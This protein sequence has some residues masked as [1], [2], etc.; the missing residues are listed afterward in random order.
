MQELIWKVRPDVIVESGVAHGGALV[1]YA[2]ILELLG[3]GKV[4]GVD[5]EIRKYNRL[6]IEAHP[7]SHRIDLIEGDSL[8]DET[9]AA[10]RSRI[11]PGERVMVA[12]DSNHTRE[13]VRGELERYAPLVTPNSYLVVFD[14]V[15]ALVADAPPPARAGPRT[16]RSRR[17][18]TSSTATTTSRSTAPTSG[19]RSA[20]ARAASC[21]GGRATERTAPTPCSSARPPWRGLSWSSPSGTRTSAASS[22]APSRPTSS[23][24]TGWT[25]RGPVQ[26]VVQ[27]KRRHAA[28]A[29]LPGRAARRGEARPLHARRDL[30]RGRRPAARLAE[31]PAL[32]RRR[33]E[34]RRRARAVRPRGLRARLPDAGG[35]ERGPLPDLDALRARRGARRALGRPR[36]RHRVAAPRRPAGR[37]MSERDAEYPDFAP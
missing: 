35:R 1:L 4:I 22:P 27:R 31:L 33:A 15:M 26:H 20:T 14:A 24:R 30:R 5:I 37:T 2:S 11:R 10:V 16:T 7:L 32:V 21:G 6:A 9:V 18:A 19:S 13:H 3:R 17:C 36:L 34:R 28:R 8:A 12:L 23:R 25:P 29:A